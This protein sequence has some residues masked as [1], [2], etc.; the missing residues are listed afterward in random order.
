MLTLR[1]ALRQIRF[2]RL[3]SVLLVLVLLVPIC[4]SSYWF[5]LRATSN[6]SVER[7]IVWTFG[8]AAA[9]VETLVSDV[10]ELTAAG[11]AETRES[12]EAILGDSSSLSDEVSATVVLHNGDASLALVGFGLASADISAGRFVPI[13]G[14]WP[15]TDEEVVLSPSVASALGIDTGSTVVAADG[16]ELRVVGLMAKAS[17]LD[18]RFAVMTPNTAAELAVPLDELSPNDSPPSL[19]WSLAQPPAPEVQDRLESS[20]W[21]VSLRETQLRALQADLSGGDVTNV[22]LTGLAALAFVELTLI[23]AGVYSIL[24][25]SK[26]RESGLLATVGASLKIRR[27]IARWDGT[28]LALTAAMVGVTLGIAG[29]RIAAPIFA[30]RENQVWEDFHIPWLWLLLLVSI[31]V[32]AGATAASLAARQLKSDV[33]AAL[34]GVEAFEPVTTRH[35]LGMATIVLAAIGLSVSVV[36][37]IAKMPVLVLLAIVV[38]VVAAATFIRYLY[39]NL[40]HRDLRGSVEFRLAAKA[41]TRYPGRSTAFSL[42][43]LTLVVLT[44]VVTAMLGGLAKATA[45]AYVPA[46]PHGSVT[47][48]ATKPLT[49][50]TAQALAVVFETASAANFTAVAP[51]EPPPIDG[52]RYTYW[53]EYTL[54]DEDP[55][56]QPL[57]LYCGTQSDVETVLGRPLTDAEASAFAFGSALVTSPVADAADTITVQAPEPTG[58]DPA[59]IV[60]RLQAMVVDSSVRY[61]I[62]PVVMISPNGVSKLGGVQQPTSSLIYL[63]PSLRSD[64]ND[65]LEARAQALLSADVGRQ[66]VQI[67]IEDGSPA[68]YA[69]RTVVIFTLVVML[70]ASTAVAMLVVGLASNELRLTLRVLDDTGAS[71]RSRRLFSSMQATFVATLGVAGALV[72]TAL[73]TIQLLHAANL[74]FSIWYVLG[75]AAA[76]VL[77]PLAA[78]LTGSLVAQ[79]QAI[80]GERG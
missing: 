31:A 75:T 52:K 22:W 36:G 35:K 30:G 13:D 18:S 11:R 78:V 25:A 29:A 53:G 34:A 50:S 20:G 32:T 79:H 8:S 67:D 62:S 33:V 3:R 64:S 73:T 57:S 14:A 55:D 23:I 40:L 60:R 48:Y 49:S 80:P 27:R 76:A 63:P 65:Q 9:I 51:P 28:L 59:P 10:G 70:L 17:S 69:L 54:Q 77:A 21:T 61:T 45:Q 72:I 42:V 37:A 46:G 38:L 4:L 26:L 56:T 71:R 7:Q 6:I 1:L 16:T 41:S 68:A 12:L 44:S 58:D 2:E 74:P 66:Y 39:S 5:T 24:Y 19:Q 47:V 43:I 15:T